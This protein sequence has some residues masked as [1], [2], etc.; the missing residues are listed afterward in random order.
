MRDA[1]LIAAPPSEVSSPQFRPHC[2][3]GAA[4]DRRVP[5]GPPLGRVPGL[6]FL[7]IRLPPCDS[8]LQERRALGRL[9]HR[10]PRGKRCAELLLGPPGSRL[11]DPLAR[12]SPLRAL[13]LPLMTGRDTCTTHKTGKQR[14]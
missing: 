10:R 9:P 2:S 13:P 1:N 8:A 14:A 5:D 7:N 11:A 4:R 12:P 6:G 3:T